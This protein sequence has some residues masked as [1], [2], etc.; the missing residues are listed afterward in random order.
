MKLN[1]RPFRVPVDDC[2]KEQDRQGIERPY[3]LRDITEPIDAVK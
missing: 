2:Y 3:V 1:E